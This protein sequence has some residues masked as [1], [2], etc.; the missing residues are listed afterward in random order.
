MVN[1]KSGNFFVWLLTLPLL[2]YSMFRNLDLIMSTMGGDP[3]SIVAGIGALFALDLGVLFWLAAFN[4]ARG[5]QRS[6]SGILIVLDLLGAFAGLLA[7]TLLKGGGADNLDLIRVVSQWAIPVIIGANFAAGIA[8]HAS[9]P[10]KIIR[11]RQRALDDELRL[12]LADALASNSGSVVEAALPAALANMQAEAK[13][14][15]LAQHGGRGAGTIP[16]QPNV[17]AID[18]TALAAALQAAGLG[19][20]AESVPAS[21]NGHAKRSGIAPKA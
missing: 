16:A 3:G 15:F 4:G 6:I 19:L 12:K 20:P 10:D 9:D 5:T 11:D 8:Y 21:Q 2:A 14:H 17:P 18:Y 1:N 13:A 7:D